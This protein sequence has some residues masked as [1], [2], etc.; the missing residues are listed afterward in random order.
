LLGLLSVLPLAACAE[1]AATI[2]VAVTVLAGPVCPA[3][4]D[5]PDPACADRPVEGAELVVVG[6]NDRTVT[7]VHTDANGRT[8]ISLPPGTYTIRPQPVPGLMGT[9]GDVPLVVDGFTPELTIGY[10]TGIR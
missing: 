4:S 5:P 6:R 9:P 1:P 3:V 8:S 10:D 2:S 7:T